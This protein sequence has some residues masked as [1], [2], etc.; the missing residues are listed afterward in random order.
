MIGARPTLKRKLAMRKI[1][2]VV[3][4]WRYSRCL[5][6]LLSSLE[7]NRA[8]SAQIKVTVFWNAKDQPT[9]DVLRYFRDHSEMGRWPK[10]PGEQSPLH[11]YQFPLELPWLLRRA[12]GRNMA[13]L[14]T[15]ADLVWFCDGDY[16]FGPDCLETLA[17]ME[18]PD[19]KLFFPREV[20]ISK[21]HALGDAASL[22]AAAGPGI[23]RIDPNDYMVSKHRAIG[24]LQIVPGDVAREYGYCRYTKWQ[25]LVTDGKWKDTKGDMA[26]RKILETNGTAISLP[27][28]YRIRQTTEGVVDT[29]KPS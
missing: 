29:L 12:I 5:S 3:H 23:Y 15:T 9:L 16:V 11:L 6:Y 14:K 8:P 13:A 25:R 24:G 22:K 18:L 7:I 17:T 2:L 26:F 21:T 20:M 19:S 10:Y 4:C 27:R 28:L 1:E